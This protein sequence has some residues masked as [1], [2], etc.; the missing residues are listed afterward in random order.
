M[1]IDFPSFPDDGQE[2]I[3]PVTGIKYTYDVT[4]GLWKTFSPSPIGYQGSFG[5]VGFQGS[6][7]LT[8]FRGSIG[9]EGSIGTQGNVGFQGSLGLPGYLGS[10]NVG[11][12]GSAGD[13]GSGG[14]FSNGQSIEVNNLIVTGYLFANN[15]N[16]GLM[17][18]GG[19]YAFKFIS[20]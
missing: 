7:G 6:S 12:Q 16:E 3:N 14:G 10:V 5:G 4:Y 18:Y 20:F 1:A 19:V 13:I 17:D 9:F 8:G 11:Y 15:N 2:F